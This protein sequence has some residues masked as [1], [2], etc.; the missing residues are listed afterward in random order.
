MERK[1]VKMIQTRA[2]LTKAG[3]QLL[4]RRV[5]EQRYLYN[6]ALAHRRDAYRMRGES[7]SK[8]QQSAEFTGVRNEDLTEYLEVDRRLSIG[9]LDRLHKAY[10]AMF[11]RWRRGESKSGSPRFKS[12][13]RF[14]TLEIYS[15]ANNYLKLDE[16]SNKGHIQIKGLPRLRFKCGR[17]P[18]GQQPK[19]ILITRKPN[20]VYISMSF[21]FDAAPMPDDDAPP[22]NPIGIDVGVNKRAT[23]SNGETIERREP[24][25]WEREKRRLLRK[26]QRQRDAAIEDGRAEWIFDGFNRKT[27]QRKYR[28]KWIEGKYSKSYAKTRRRYEK[29]SHRVN[30]RNYNTLHRTSARLVAKYDFIAVEDLPIKNMTRSARGTEDEP[31]RNV[32]QKR[33]L[34]RE[35]LY[36][37]WGRF[38][39][40]LAYKAES[41]GKRF[42]KVDPKYTSQTCPSCGTIDAKS[43][44]GE[45]YD[46][47]HC[48]FVGDADV[49]GATNAL[50]RGMASIGFP[51][52]GERIPRGAPARSSTGS[53]DSARPENRDRQLILPGFS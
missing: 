27:G 20:G 31:G 26:M 14:R 9:T 4:D 28:F 1:S 12:K 23:L 42:V 24:R 7:V 43:R 53:L 13:S 30:V 19:H 22:A 32:A 8:G 5:E 35:I 40:Y 48:D 44:R 38:I 36:Q 17:I 25:S 3:H 41:A 37:N 2:Y 16:E 51:C 21:E 50:V 18:A 11:G 45:S 6:C 29:A 34:T 15:G 33:A 52:A 39:Q 46:C 10:N 49:V 47:Q